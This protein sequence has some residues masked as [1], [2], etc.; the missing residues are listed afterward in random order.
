MNRTLILALSLLSLGAAE[1]AAITKPAGL[2]TEEEH[3][4]V[5]LQNRLCADKELSCDY[6]TALL[7]DPRLTIYHPPKPTGPPPAPVPKEQERNPYLTKRFGLLTPE[8]LE[9]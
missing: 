7:T 2:T 5:E 8:S 6:V 1:T 9:R 4:K 3:R